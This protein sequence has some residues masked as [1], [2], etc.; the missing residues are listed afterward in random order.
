MRVFITG[1]SSGIGQALARQ[2]GVPGASVA[3]VARRQTELERLAE[4]L[5]ESGATATVYA[6]DVADTAAM[7]DAARDFAAR[8]GRVDR[9]I[10]N[11]GIGIRDTLR[12]GDA[13]SVAR[14]MSVNV[15]GATNTIV[16]FIPVLLRQ[17]SGTLVAVSSMAGHRAWPAPRA[18]SESSAR[19]RPSI[20]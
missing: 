20:A 4:E 3:L 19:S 17:G 6:I 15:I 12:E 18:K 8:E 10:A 1:A 5:R 14:L 11:A 2:Y 16:P 7:C 13:A 9:V